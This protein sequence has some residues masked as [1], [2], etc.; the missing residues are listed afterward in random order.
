[1]KHKI[2]IILLFYF[3]IIQA[4]NSEW[5]FYPKASIITCFAETGN[6]LWIGSI[7]GLVKM[8]KTTGEKTYYNKSTCPIQDNYIT[9][10]EVGN[11]STIWFGTLNSGIVKFD[12]LEWEVYNTFNSPLIYNASSDI[13]I[14]SDNNRWIATNLNYGGLTCF[15]GAEWKNYNSS[16]SKLP[17]DYVSCIFSEGTTVWVGCVG[18]LVKIDGANWTIYITSNSNISGN[19]IL[20]M[21]NDS[22]GNLWL[23]HSGGLEKYDGNSFSVIDATNSNIQKRTNASMSIDK[24]DVIWTGCRNSLSDIGGVLVFNGSFWTKFDTINSPISDADIYTIFAD[25]SGYVWI[26]GAT[27]G[28]VDQKQG[29]LW[30]QFNPSRIE[31][32]INDGGIS[33]I[34]FDKVDNIYLHTGTELL[35][36]NWINWNL[37][38]KYDES[39]RV[40]ATDMD[41]NLYERSKKTLFKY[42][43]I[44]WVDISADIPYGN[45]DIGYEIVIDNLNNIWIDC[46]LKVITTP[47]SGYQIQEGLA[48]NSGQ[49]WIIDKT[50]DSLITGLSIY[51]IKIDLWNNIWLGTNKGLI[52]YNR[53]ELEVYD[54]SNSLVSSD[55]TRCIT[56]DSLN[57]I[58]LSDGNF[59]LIRFNG[60]IWEHYPHPELYT[61]T[62]SG[63]EL[64]TDIDGSIWQR[65]LFKIIRFDGKTWTTLDGNNSPLPTNENVTALSIDKYGNKWIGTASGFLVY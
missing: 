19:S 8:N 21:V 38:R 27:N 45:D 2:I 28:L 41:G 7:A 17:I 37:L 6:Y 32:N 50:L 14:D 10:I 13:E 42:D 30:K 31:L 60:A 24:N 54:M 59:G 52:K 51:D 12:G 63:S 35:K 23:L 64:K 22:K 3:P 5:L 4:Q 44:N 55:N 56:I 29:E 20:E 58:W 62:N 65:T 43:G 16:N 47:D 25:E 48:F 53:T 1:M 15:N 11:N 18:R 36:Y 9:D 46:I 33:N 40:F 26:G 34:L 49:E 57:N 61:Y 39:Y